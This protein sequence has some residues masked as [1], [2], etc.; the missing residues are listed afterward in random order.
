MHTRNGANKKKSH[1]KTFGR[2]SH[3]ACSAL[4]SPSKSWLSLSL[5]IPTTHK[6]YNVLHY[7][8]LP[9]EANTIRK[10]SD[11]FECAIGAEVWGRR[12]TSS[13]FNFVFRSKMTKKHTH[14]NIHVSVI[15][16]MGTTAQVHS[17]CFPIIFAQILVDLCRCVTSPDSANCNVPN[18]A[19][20]KR[21]GR[22]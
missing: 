17:R 16:P 11:V 12:C 3:A 15:G 8:R 22:Q 14:T 1:E 9:R 13:F 10:H 4:T 20:N 19:K 7:M 6:T 18:R 21:N 5:C 2:L